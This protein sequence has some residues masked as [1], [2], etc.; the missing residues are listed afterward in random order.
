MELG[1]TVRDA[2]SAERRVGYT[3]DVNPV[4]E[5]IGMAAFMARL[6]SIRPGLPGLA[7]SVARY[8]D[9]FHKSVLIP[10]WDVRN[11]VDEMWQFKRLYNN[12][13]AQFY[14]Y[15]MYR[16]TGDVKYLR[17]SWQ[18]LIRYFSEGGDKFCGFIF[19]LPQILDALCREGLSHEE[20]IL[21]EWYRRYSDFLVGQG[22]SFETSEVAYESTIV[23]PAAAFLF[24]AYR[25][26]G[27]IRYLEQ[28]KRYTDLLLM[29]Q[30]TQPDYRLHGVSV[31]HWDGFWFGKRQLWGDTMP[32]YWSSISGVAFWEACLSTGDVSFR[33]LAWNQIMP[34]FGNLLPGGGASCAYVYPLAVDEEPAHLHD[35]YANDQDWAYY[36]YLCTFGAENRTDSR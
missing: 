25:Y 26:L 15:E 10:E 1:K 20:N 32:H 29:F 14:L 27:D 4:R 8:D 18:V 17:E 16:T 36:F 7:E 24:Q 6:L 2:A 19:S 33:A 30:G 23:A 11:S 21:T 22:D 3:P 5:R 28:A 31:R 12:S 9:F 34:N 13:F 35:P